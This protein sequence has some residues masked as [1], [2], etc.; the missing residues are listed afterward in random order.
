MS[1]EHM[2]KQIMCKSVQRTIW[3]RTFDR[4]V[5]AF[6]EHYKLG[7]QDLAFTTSDNVV[8]SNIMD[9]FTNIATNKFHKRFTMCISHNFKHIIV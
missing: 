9:F 6:L 3:L 5:N 2:V 7:H 8:D 4:R 1:I